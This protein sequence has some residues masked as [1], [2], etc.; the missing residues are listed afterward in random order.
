[1]VFTMVSLETQQGNLDFGKE[2]LSS[3]GKQNEVRS[4]VN[5]DVPKPV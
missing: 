4:A 1:M 2:V 5:V 3:S